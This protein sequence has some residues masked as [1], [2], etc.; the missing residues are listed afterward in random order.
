MRVSAFVCAGAK[1]K[2]WKETVIS[3]NNEMKES[4]VSL[5]TSQGQNLHVADS[6]IIDIFRIMSQSDY[7][8]M[9]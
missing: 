6:S 3:R 9:D 1:R 4:Y 5:S 7:G 8:K 2:V